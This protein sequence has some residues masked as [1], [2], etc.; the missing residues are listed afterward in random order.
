[1]LSIY[2]GP[3]FSGKTTTLINMYNVN[4][5]NHKIIIDY[6][7]DDLNNDTHGVL[8][9]HDGIK[10]PCIK[11]RNFASQEFNEKINDA[12]FIYI[13][14]AQFFPDLFQFVSYMLSMNKTIYIYG[15]DG[16]YKQNKIGHILD[17]IP[18]CDH[19]HKLKGKCFTCNNKSLF[20]KRITKTKQQYLPD[21]KQ[22]IPLCRKCFEL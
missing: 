5:S 22:Y 21:E 20:S 2:V 18:L 13:N 3:M 12:S 7:I 9:S 14:E 8:E 17:L 16:D 6:N 10:L 1:M 15:L 4:K 19:I 11:C